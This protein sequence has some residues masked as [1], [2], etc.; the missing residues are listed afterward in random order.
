MDDL[1]QI[2]LTI[3]TLMQRDAIYI[4]CHGNLKEGSFTIEN[5][6]KN[7]DLGTESCEIIISNAWLSDGSK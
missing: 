3:I 4:T 5:Y 1:R 7:S 2:L 6:F